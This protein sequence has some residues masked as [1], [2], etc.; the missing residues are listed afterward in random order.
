MFVDDTFNVKNSYV[1]NTKTFLKSSMEKV[2]FKENP[3]KQR[4]Y[5][6]NWVLNKTNNKISD[7]FPAGS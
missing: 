6:N 3:E 7:L 4:Q 2:N 1:E 5:I